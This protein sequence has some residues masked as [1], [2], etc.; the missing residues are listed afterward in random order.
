MPS[1]APVHTAAFARLYDDFIVVAAALLALS[2]SG[3]VT[4]DEP[5]LAVE[6][7]PM[8][9]ST[10]VLV[11]AVVPAMPGGRTVVILD[12]WRFPDGPNTLTLPDH[13]G[14]RIV[15]A[16]V[17]TLVATVNGTEHALRPGE[18]VVVPTGQGTVRNPEPTAAEALIL[19]FTQWTGEWPHDRGITWTASI[20]YATETLPAGSAQVVLQR[21]T[22][23]PFVTGVPFQAGPF[24]WL[25]VEEGEVILLLEGEGDPPG[26]VSGQERGVGPTWQRLLPVPPGWH[27]TLRNARE[28]PV[29][30]YRLSVTPLTLR[31][32]TREFTPP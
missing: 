6:A 26:W 17:G 15:L 24:E 28:T 10:D 3:L 32:S 19:S 8:T 29:A 25:G 9:L 22:L 13:T 11:D 30:L 16:T 5:R 12:R 31:V 1:N 4:R 18:S 7:L 20:E 2:R 14:P 21:L 27:G 23:P